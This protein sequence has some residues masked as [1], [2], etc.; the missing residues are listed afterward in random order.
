[1]VE[2]EQLLPMIQDYGFP[3]VVT[4]YLLHRIEGKLEKLNTTIME[5]PEK[6]NGNQTYPESK[7]TVS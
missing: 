5:L 3:A 2:L 1:M 6:M 7:K 4:F